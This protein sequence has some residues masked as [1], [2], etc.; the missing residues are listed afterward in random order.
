MGCSRVEIVHDLRNASLDQEEYNMIIYDNGDN[1][2]LTLEK[3]VGKQGSRKVVCADVGWLTDC[4]I[5]G[6]L[7][8]FRLKK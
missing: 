1:I 6:R 5:S 8:R 3:K 4:L 2:P 7:L